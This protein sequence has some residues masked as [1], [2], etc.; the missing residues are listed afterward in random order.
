VP[1]TATP[2]QVRFLNTLTTLWVSSEEGDDG[3]SLIEHLAP[4]GDSPPLHVHH[5]E[6]EVIYFLASSVSSSTR[7]S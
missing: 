3:L 5:T 6:D 7:R 2:S 4:H 1:A